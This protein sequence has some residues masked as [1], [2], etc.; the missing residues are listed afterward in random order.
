MTWRVVCLLFMFIGGSLLL[1]WYLVAEGDRQQSHIDIVRADWARQKRMIHFSPVPATYYVGFGLQW[2]RSYFGA[3]GLVDKNLVF[4]GLRR[5]EEEWVPEERIPFDQIRWI[6]THYIT[7]QKGRS[8]VNQDALIVHY[9]RGGF[10]HMAAWVAD[11]QQHLAR[12]LSAETGLPVLRYFGE[13]EDYGPAHA[14][15]LIEDVYGRWHPFCDGT[16]PSDPDGKSAERLDADPG[17]LY[18]A[19]DRLLFNRRDPIHLAQVRRVDLFEPGGVLAELN[20]F[21][22]DLLRIEYE[23]L[24]QQHKVIGLLVRGGQ[25][26]ASAIHTLTSVP[27]EHH[28]GRKKKES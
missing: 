6:G 2:P 18:L 8:A 1:I 12:T 20:P 24:E 26:W 13:R 22:E 10:W 7:G 16:Y 28:R 21:H 27:Y 9:E 11:Q 14:A 15:R 25:G 3:L 17:E 5:Y 23:S 19:P 4:I